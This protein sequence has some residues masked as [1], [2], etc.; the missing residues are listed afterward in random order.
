MRNS[1][2][3]TLERTSRAILRLVQVPLQFVLGN[4]IVGA[5]RLMIGM[6]YLHVEIVRKRQCLLG[7]S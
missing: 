6:R 3:L 4:E 5:A 1:N 7:V 2:R